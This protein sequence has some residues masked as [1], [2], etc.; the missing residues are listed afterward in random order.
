MSSFAV[1]EQELASQSQVT[2]IIRVFEELCATSVVFLR[3]TAV[4][5]KA[6][7]KLRG[8]YGTERLPAEHIVKGFGREEPLPAFSQRYPGQA[9]DGG[10]LWTRPDLIFNRNMSSALRSAG[11]GSTAFDQASPDFPWQRFSFDEGR[12]LPLDLDRMLFLHPCWRQDDRATR[13]VL[14]SQGKN[15]TFTHW[16]VPD[17]WFWV[18][19]RLWHDTSLKIRHL[20]MNHEMLFDFHSLGV[21][22][23]Q[24]QEWVARNVAFL[25]INSQ[26][27]SDSMKDW[28]PFYRMAT[29]PQAPF[30]PDKHAPSG[31]TEQHTH[32]I[33]HRVRS[34]FSVFMW[35]GR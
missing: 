15:V 6:L 14:T 4:A 34:S 30:I 27:D 7:A 26:H 8:F 2:E 22:E 19:G 35:G 12:V 17:V 31:E 29:R 23:P 32:T 1:A 28:N 10:V 18:P 11:R 16:R 33:L 24:L 5:K 20:T 21:P 9:C 25:N 3:T 13:E